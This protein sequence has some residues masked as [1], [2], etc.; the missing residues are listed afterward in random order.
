MSVLNDE[1]IFLGSAATPQY[2][3]LD[4]ANRHGLVTGA[5]GTGKTVTLQILAE[6]FSRA[7][8]PVFCAD[9]KG[10]LS[11]LATAGEAKDFLLKRAAAIGLD[12]YRFEAS[13]AVFWDLFGKAG[14]PVRTTISEMGPVLLARLLELNDTQEGVLAI[15]FRFADD[16]GLAILDL[17]DLRALMLHVS[18]EAATLSR[19]Y[20]RVSPA[21][22]AAIQRALLVLEEQGADHFFGEPALSIADLMRTRDG[23]GVV[24]VLDATAL[25]MRPRL[26]AT[27]LLWLLS[28]LFEE[29]PEVGDPDKPGLVFFFDEAHLLFDDAPAALIDRIEQV[30]RLIRSKGVGVYFV[31]QNPLDVP[32]TVLG[33][34]G[35]RVQHALR[36]FTPRDQKA[37]RSA[38]ETFRPNPALDTAAVITELGVGEALVST[39]GEKGV[40]SMVERTLIRPPS[41]RLGPLT[42]AERA[43]LVAASPMGAKYDAPLD[44]ESAYEVLQ[45]RAAAA[46]AEPADAPAEAPKRESEP[47]DDE[48]RG[49]VTR[50]WWFLF[51]GPKRRRLTGTQRAA[52]SAAR[53]M[54]AEAGGRVGR[55]LGGASGARLGKQIARGVLGGI[56]RR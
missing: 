13:P 35:N 33:Q 50:L 56:L 29:L 25:M 24:N 52:R 31:T 2:L 54:A 6:G 51:G 41:G 5:T 42:E 43:A 1:A 3:R 45:K 28:E 53:S 20:G 10:D 7:G 30:V 23:R 40:P 15:A 21:S 37:V 36:A 19:T 55:A 44:R 46:A 17:K 12:D 39:L 26:Y 49:A 32:E 8:V 11:G 9:I 22:V 18:D 27:F 4:M 47:Q 48:Q 34:L 16:E 14:H 38:A